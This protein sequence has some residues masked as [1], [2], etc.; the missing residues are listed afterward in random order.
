MQRL[1]TVLGPLTVQYDKVFTAIILIPRI[2]FMEPNI[3]AT[4]FYSSYCREIPV[5]SPM[6]KWS[7][8]A[9]NWVERMRKKVGLIRLQRA[10]YDDCQHEQFKFHIPHLTVNEKAA[11]R[12]HAT[13]NTQHATR[14]TQHATPAL[15]QDSIELY[16]TLG[17][18]S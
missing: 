6:E 11:I 3:F 13:R 18:S 16:R 15:I 9:L 2:F 7:E 1:R 17:N 8:K 5:C 10:R 4:S 14:N 12:S